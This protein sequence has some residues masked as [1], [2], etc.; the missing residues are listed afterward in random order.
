M[1]RIINHF[2][3]VLKNVKAT[4]QQVDCTG[5]GV[6]L[7]HKNEVVLEE[8]WGKQ[9][10]HQNA[11]SIYKN[12]QFHVASVRKS[13]IGFAIAYAVHYG[14]IASI[15]DPVLKYFPVYTE[16]I[17]AGVT[18]R[19][20]LTHTHGLRLINNQVEHEFEPGTDWAYRGAGIEL[21][22]DIVKRATGKD[23]ATIIKENVIKPLQLQ[24]TG[25]Y[26]EMQ[27]NFVEVI[28]S[29]DDPAWYTSGVTD[30]SKMNMYVS[31]RD[32]AKWG[33]LHLNRG[34]W[35]GEQMVVPEIF[36]CLTSI[37]SPET[38]H[39]KAPINGYLWF[40]QKDESSNRDRMEIG[41]KVPKYSYQILGY[42][43]VTLLVIPEYDLV[44]VRAFNSFGS[45]LE[46]DYL[47]DVRSF[48]DT[49]MRC[50]HKSEDDN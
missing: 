17:Y 29:E 27:Q 42:T 9:S 25:W 1:G 32:L 40:V 50:L 18:I 31:I 24:E 26:G 19:H 23:V 33:L 35:Q 2:D 8:Y 16:N 5:A 30:G 22:T 44:A 10:K 7:I 45:P 46:F 49:V 15:D 39:H 21:L 47:K 14:Y 6:M 37:Q 12:T 41:Q 48:G 43:G 13:Y 34:K 36:E 4:A 11:P 3:D 38:L 20:L 28:R